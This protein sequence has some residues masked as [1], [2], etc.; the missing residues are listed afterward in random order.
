MEVVGVLNEQVIAGAQN[1]GG[2]M[3]DVNNI[4]Y[5]P[6]NAMQYRFWTRAAA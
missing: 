3:L 1:S 6:L 2:T 5:I 4:I